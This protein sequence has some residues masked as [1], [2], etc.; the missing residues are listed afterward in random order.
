MNR[1][2]LLARA[3]ELGCWN[4][5]DAKL[6]TDEQLRDAIAAEEAAGEWLA[7][8]EALPTDEARREAVHRLRLDLERIA[9]EHRADA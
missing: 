2:E 9:D 5:D 8:L 7:K 4:P 6:A 1:D 3:V